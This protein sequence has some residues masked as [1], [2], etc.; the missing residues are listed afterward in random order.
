MEQILL[1]SDST[2]GGQ[3]INLVGEFDAFSFVEDMR[4][5]TCCLQNIIKPLVIHHNI[6]FQL[7]CRLKSAPQSG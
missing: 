1:G 2:A 5:T 3:Y 7:T 6:G 4:N